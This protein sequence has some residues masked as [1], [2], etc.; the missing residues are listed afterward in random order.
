MIVT[1]GSQ[2]LTRNA[3]AWVGP[4][5]AIVIGGH[6]RA[7]DARFV[8]H[9]TTAGGNAVEAV[10][11]PDGDSLTS[12]ARVPGV[13]IIAGSNNASLVVWR[14]PHWSLLAN[15]SSSHRVESIVAVPSGILFAQTNVVTHF[16]VPTRTFCPEHPLGFADIHRIVSI[17]N[18]MVLLP[19]H[20]SGDPDVVTYAT[21]APP[22]G[23]PPPECSQ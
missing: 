21:Y 12:I 16:D 10:P 5:E 11:L 7:G 17:K 4:G 9:W 22:A 19:K 2:A 23:A 13:G 14:Q 20:S 1:T 8:D 18:G 3:V 15:D 6:D